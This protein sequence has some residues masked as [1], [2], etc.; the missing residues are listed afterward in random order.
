MKKE[1]SIILLLIFSIALIIANKPD[2]SDVNVL[3]S[4]KETSV[5]I[6][7]IA[8]EIYPG[9]FS[10]P[11]VKNIDGENIE[12]YA[13]IHYKNTEAKPSGIKTGGTTCYSFLANSAKWKNT[14]DYVINPTNNQNLNETFI[15]NNLGL[16][17]GKWEIASTKDIIGSGTLTNDVL[18]ADTS[19]PDGKNEV[20]FGSISN[21][22]AIA[23]TIVWGIFSGPIQQRK[24]IEWDQVYDQ[25]DF[26]WSSNGEYGKMDFENIAT[27]EL[28]H[29]FGLADLYN[30]ACSE[31]TMYGYAT[32]GEIKKRDLSSG[33]ILGIKKLYN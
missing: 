13:I 24:I 23:V 18:I 1:I 31:E 6:P 26:N 15:L 11:A 20:Y 2:F 10:L 9:V 19:S 8:L 27:H 3:S 14:E 25:Y 28:G 21:Q 5:S 32:E 16:N 30:S 17:I 29:T 4:K 22:G 7:T 12:G 33:D